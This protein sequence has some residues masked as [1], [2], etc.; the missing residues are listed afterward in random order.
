MSAEALSRVDS[1]IVGTNLA[2]AGAI[3]LKH[4]RGAM[5]LVPAGVTQLTYYACATAGGTYKLVSNVGTAGVETTTAETWHNL[6]VGLFPVH[7]LKIVGNGSTATTELQA[8]S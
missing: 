8:K 3:N 1:V 4:D 7:F 5:L 6:P 2:A